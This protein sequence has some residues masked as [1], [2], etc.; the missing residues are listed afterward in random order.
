MKVILNLFLFIFFLNF[1]FSQTEVKLRDNFNTELSG[2]V[3]TF[4]ASNLYLTYL[5]QDLIYK[6]FEAGNFSKKEFKQFVESLNLISIQIDENLKKLYQIVESDK[7]AKLILEVINIYESL[8][9]SNVNLLQ[10]LDKKTEQEKEIYLNH[11]KQ[12]WEKIRNITKNS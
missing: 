11:K 8:K 7:D 2:I 9:T 12:L 4:A 6:S 5:S 10:Y 3:G 1:A